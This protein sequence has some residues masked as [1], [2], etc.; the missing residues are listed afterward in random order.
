MN[1]Q[2]SFLLSSFKA[3]NSAQI[4]RKDKLQEIQ[5]QAKIFENV[6]KELEADLKTSQNLNWST[7]EKKNLLDQVF[8]LQEI[9]ESQRIYSFNG[10]EE[11]TKLF[12]S[13]QKSYQE[14]L[15]EVEFNKDII[16]KKKDEI[17]RAYQDLI[18]MI[19]KLSNMMQIFTQRM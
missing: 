17:L 10:T 18:D 5:D 8:D 14:K 1:I 12:Q 2:R 6:Q 3:Q 4:D 13:I 19:Q 16:S 7:G 9:N 15:H 11:L